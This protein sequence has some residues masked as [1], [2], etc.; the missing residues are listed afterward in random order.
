[1]DEYMSRYFPRLNFIQSLVAD[2]IQRIML[3]GPKKSPYNPS[4]ETMKRQEIAS[5]QYKDVTF[6]D[7]FYQRYTDD[8]HNNQGNASHCN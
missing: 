7:F 6:I 2:T 8:T 5:I 1:M 4:N 3:K